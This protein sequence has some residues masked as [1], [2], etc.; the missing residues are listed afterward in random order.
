MWLE[1][2]TKRITPQGKI[3][4]GLPVNLLTQTK[5]KIRMNGLCA[6]GYI[7]VVP[8][9]FDLTAH[10]TNNLIT[11]TGMNKMEILAGLGLGLL[12]HLQVVIC[13]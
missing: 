6:N 11:G 12:G 3:T 9:Q 1:N 8:A 2:L 13:L 4:I 7:S 5:V 10:H